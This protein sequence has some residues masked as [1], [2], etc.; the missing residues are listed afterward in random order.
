MGT[1]E[2]LSIEKHW[3][4][5]VGPAYDADGEPNFQDASG[6]LIEGIY[7]D[8]PNN[9]YHSLPA[10]SSSK[11]KKFAES[12][13][14]YYRQYLSD[15]ERART[16]TQVRTFDTG[17]MG[18]ELVLEPEGFHDRYFRLPLMHE[19]DDVLVTI[20]DL[21]TKCEELKLKT[22]GSKP[23]LI[24]R[25]LE[26][27]PKLPIFDAIIAQTL[28]DN[29][30]A[31]AYAAAEKFISEA[32]SRMSI[33]RAFEDESI[34]ELCDKI[35]LD[36]IMWDDAHRIAKSAKDHPYADKLISNGYP[37]LTVI[38][39]DPRT[40]LMLKVKYDWLRFDSIAVDVKTTRSAASSGFAYQCADLRY[41][42]Q[43]EFYKYVGNLAGIPIKIFV[44]IAIEYADADICEPYELSDDDI[45]EGYRDLMGYLSKLEDCLKLDD[46]FGY[47]RRDRITVLKLP[48][49]RR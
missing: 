11:L 32:K 19:I 15:I 7:T 44:F 28:R 5:R 37:E 20:D 35:P 45:E 38:A 30:G 27:A 24:K 13:A 34:K 42:I 1:A 46:W 17:S 48:A 36:G 6:N 16:L 40:G 43:Q 33:V 2:E 18:H 12:P 41:D 3:L 21:K 39:R 22:S 14:H 9:V 8:L 10:I 4:D 29:V 49:R 31:Q 47:T 25:L 23:E 26:V